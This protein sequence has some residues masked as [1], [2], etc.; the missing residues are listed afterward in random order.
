MEE[1]RD[2]KRNGNGAYK[3]GKRL[4]DEKS[5][6]KMEQRITPL[7]MVDDS[8]MSGEKPLD[9]SKEL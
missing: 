9:K 4:R 1:H 3:K 7:G 5:L 8:K 6:W 2:I